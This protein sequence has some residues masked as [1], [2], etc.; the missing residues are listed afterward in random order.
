MDLSNEQRGGTPDRMLSRVA[1]SV[2][3]ADTRQ[4]GTIGKATTGIERWHCALRHA[5]AN[6]A[7]ARQP[8]LL[9]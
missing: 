4:I 6:H 3:E 8:I 9:I 5:H 2:K 7:Y 1:A